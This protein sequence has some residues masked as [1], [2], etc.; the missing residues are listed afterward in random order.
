MTPRAGPAMT[1]D[2][3]DRVTGRVVN[4]NDNFR[5]V[6]P[7]RTVTGTVTGIFPH[8]RTNV[9]VQTTAGERLTIRVGQVQP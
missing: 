3:G 8:A 4:E 1:A 6:R 5:L 2:F 7:S 9:A